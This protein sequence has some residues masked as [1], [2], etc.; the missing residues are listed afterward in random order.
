MAETYKSL[1]LDL[2]GT[3][4]RVADGEGRPNTLPRGLGVKNIFEGAWQRANQEE[5]SA[6]ST[7][8]VSTINLDMCLGLYLIFI[9]GLKRK[10]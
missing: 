1:I 9:L 5:K 2:G 10:A 7:S 6:D 4:A 3:P 8:D